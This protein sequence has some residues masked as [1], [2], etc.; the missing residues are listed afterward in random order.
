MLPL[1]SLAPDTLAR[2]IHL[3]GNIDK[4]LGHLT[5]FI[6]F[7]YTRQT[8]TNNTLPLE[9]VQFGFEVYSP[10]TFSPVKLSN[11]PP[12]GVAGAACIPRGHSNVVSHEPLR[13]LSPERRCSLEH[14]ERITN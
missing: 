13:S 1:A 14:C 12:Q 3:T 11:L 9:H 4:H 6:E 5:Q 8:L 2:H 7:C 10:L